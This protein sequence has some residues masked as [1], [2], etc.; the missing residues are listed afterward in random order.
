MN[1]HKR[2]FIEW[3]T[4]AAV[5]EHLQL[6]LQEYDPELQEKH[7]AYLAAL[8]RFASNGGDTTALHQAYRSAIVSDALFA[9]Q[10]GF[11]ANLHHFRQPHMPNFTDVDFEDMYQEHIMMTMPKRVAAE[12]LYS[13]IEKEYFTTDEVWCQAIREY[14]IDLEV[15][16]P[17]LMHFEGYKAGNAWFPLTIP[18]Y[19]ED[20]TLTNIYQMQ[21][22]QYFGQ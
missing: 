20:Q 11:E 15:V 4:D 6:L 16:V 3:M 5:W 1:D 18:G 10:K 19:Q 9:F 22:S 21:I 17:K 8:E 7:E 2:C 13:A 12:K 14:I